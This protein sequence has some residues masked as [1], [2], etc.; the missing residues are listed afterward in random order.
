MV[1]FLLTVFPQHFIER[2]L[3]QARPQLR[4]CQ[5]DGLILREVERRHLVV[6]IE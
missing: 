4:L 5:F 6:E 2:E 3:A 1:D